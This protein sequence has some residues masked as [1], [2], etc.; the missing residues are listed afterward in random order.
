V[1][2]QSAPSGVTD[3]MLTGAPLPMI[4]AA[5]LTRTGPTGADVPTELTVMR[6]E[7]AAPAAPELQT[8]VIRSAGLPSGWRSFAV[9]QALLLA[10]LVSVG[11]ADNFAQFFNFAIRVVNGTIAFTKIGVEAPGTR[12][13]PGWSHWNWL[14]LSVWQNPWRR[15]RKVDRSRRAARELV[16]HGQRAIIVGRADIGHEN[17]IVAK[18]IGRAELPCDL[19]QLEVGLF[20][21]GGW[22]SRS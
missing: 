12:T 17:S 9:A 15:W 19:A 14:G 21:T 3:E 1:H 7:T 11:T 13:M 6:Q 5:S 22:H 16:N 10:R 8:F 20:S 2:D 4:V 18:T